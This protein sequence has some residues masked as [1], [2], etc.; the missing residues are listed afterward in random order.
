MQ[1]AQQA[2]LINASARLAER[3]GG[4]HVQALRWHQSGGG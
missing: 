3:H 2:Y 4:R 1:L